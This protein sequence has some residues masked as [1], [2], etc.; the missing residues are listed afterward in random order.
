VTA[1]FPDRDTWARTPRFHFP[2]CAR[3]ALTRPRW[4]WVQRAARGGGVNLAEV[5]IN[6]NTQPYSQV[7]RR[8][9][10]RDRT[11][12]PTMCKDYCT[13]GEG[14]FGIGWELGEKKREVPGIIIARKR[15]DHP[16]LPGPWKGH[17]YSAC[18]QAGRCRYLTGYVR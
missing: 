17:V 11:S 14:M 3:L 8:A 1:G 10:A 5:A 18:R 4:G 6:E 12:Q 2:Y 7:S 16:R 15:A 13:Y 9:H